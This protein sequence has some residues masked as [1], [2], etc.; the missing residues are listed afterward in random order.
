MLSIQLG[1]M[2]LLF[3][4]FAGAIWLYTCE[5]KENRTRKMGC[6]GIDTL[7]G[8]CISAAVLLP[9]AI[10]LL[11]SAR[12]G[13]NLSYFGVMK[14]HGLDDL[15][16]RLFQIAN[17]VLIGLLFASGCFRNAKGAA[18]QNGSGCI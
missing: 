17:P 6:M 10:L 5:R 3:S 16:E 15:F 4:L 7:I 18:L 8:I 9:S 2:T 11:Q 1:F 12:S 14:R 13:E